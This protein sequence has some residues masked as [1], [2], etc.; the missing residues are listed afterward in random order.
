MN[1]DTGRDAVPASAQ[2]ARHMCAMAARAR[3]IAVIGIRAGW[4]T[5]NEIA[6]PIGAPTEVVMRFPDTAVNDIC[7]HV[8]TV[9]RALWLS[10]I[11]PRHSDC[12]ERPDHQS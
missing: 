8:G 9:C 4:I 1:D 12:D 5:S 3:G 6:D 2:E 7:M 11:G 10:F